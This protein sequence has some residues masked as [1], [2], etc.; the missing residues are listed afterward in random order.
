MHILITGANGFIGK[1]LSVRLS[2]MREFEVSTFNRGET[3][4]A[5]HLK[6]NDADAIF[7]VLTAIVVLVH[8]ALFLVHDAR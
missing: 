4:E 1:N 2:E 5:L 8:Q 7:Y 3:I 6:V